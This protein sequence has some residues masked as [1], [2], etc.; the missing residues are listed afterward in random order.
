MK[1]HPDDILR[2]VLPAERAA[3]TRWYAAQQCVHPD[4][5]RLALTI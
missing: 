4:W 2:T 5:A 3:V 1:A